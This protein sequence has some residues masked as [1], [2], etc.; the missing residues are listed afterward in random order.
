M[1]EIQGSILQYFGDSPMVFYNQK[2]MIE[3]TEPI[4]I[5]V[6]TDRGKKLGLLCYAAFFFNL[7][8]TK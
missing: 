1:D 7:D 5:T 6:I 4:S 2:L 8:V 3:A